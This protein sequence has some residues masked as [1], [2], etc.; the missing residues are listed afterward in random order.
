M[1]APRS[2]VRSGMRRVPTITDKVDGTGRSTSD[3]WMPGHGVNAHGPHGRRWARKARAWLR[4]FDA[5]KDRCDHHAPI[6]PYVKRGYAAQFYEGIESAKGCSIYDDAD[7]CECDC[8]ECVAIHE[9]TAT[10]LAEA[11]VE[12]GGRR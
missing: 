10:A 6:C 8:D 3:V 1:A 7:P 2:R 11:Y 9:D 5:W 12:G 4:G